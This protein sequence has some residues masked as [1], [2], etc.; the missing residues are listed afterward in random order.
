VGD[1]ELSTRT[2]DCAPCGSDLREHTGLLLKRCNICKQWVCSDCGS[3]KDGKEH[4]EV[5]VTGN[6]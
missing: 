4:K 1:F 6:V 2:D 5:P 3:L